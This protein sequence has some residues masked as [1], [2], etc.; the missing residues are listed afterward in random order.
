MY[1]I[2]DLDTITAIK[3]PYNNNYT[4][5]TFAVDDIFNTVIRAIH[6]PIV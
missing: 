2:I 6:C 4:T 5:L 1:T 3:L